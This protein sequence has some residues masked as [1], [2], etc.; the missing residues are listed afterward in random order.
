MFSAV[1]LV[2]AS[3]FAAQAAE[4]GFTVEAN[5]PDNSFYVL[6]TGWEV[7]TQKMS[8][9]ETKKALN[10]LS[11]PLKMKNSTGGIKAYLSEAP[12]L[13]SSSS[14][15]A[16]PLSVKV[17]NKPLSV[18]ASNAV[19]ILNANE[20]STEQRVAM[21]VSQTTPFTDTTRPEAGVYRGTVTMMFDTVP[22]SPETL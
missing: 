1:A 15:K 13:R 11:Q 20:A 4:I 14:L 19:N 21:D 12:E 8:W 17:F 5:I 10:T 22:V 2:M 3:S 18:G 16:I 9:D 6:G 7:T